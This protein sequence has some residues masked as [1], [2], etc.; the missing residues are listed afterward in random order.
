MTPID[1]TEYMRNRF[2]HCNGLQLV[3]YGESTRKLYGSETNMPKKWNTD[4]LLT[5]FPYASDS[6]Y[7]I[8]L[9]CRCCVEFADVN[10]TVL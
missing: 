3:R 4:R 5:E 9:G 8:T 10:G 2:T 7:R 1:D 6:R